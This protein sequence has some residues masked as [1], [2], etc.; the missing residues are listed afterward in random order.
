MRIVVTL[1]AVLACTIAAT[2]QERF[3]YRIVV[4]DPGI[5]LGR[6]TLLLPQSL[7]R[8]SMFRVPSFSSVSRDLRLRSPFF[9][10]VLGDKV[11]LTLP[12]RLQMEKQARLQPLQIILGTVQTAGVAYIAYRHIK[13]YGLL[14]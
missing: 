4:V 11:D 2:G 6:P 5:S 9:G 14:K 13:K 10:G 3:E 7:E 8:E 1:I 12:L